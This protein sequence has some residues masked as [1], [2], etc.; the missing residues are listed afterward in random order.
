MSKRILIYMDIWFDK[1]DEEDEGEA[2]VAA[3]V[4]LPHEVEGL[5]NT[6][7]LGYLDR[8][9]RF[10]GIKDAFI[11]NYKTYPEMHNAV[12]EYI[13]KW[14]TYAKRFGYRFSYNKEYYGLKDGKYI[15]IWKG[16]EE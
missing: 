5:T 15:V 6:A 8:V 1:D 4:V 16:E 3:K 12:D 14:K 13:K 10:P 11:C 7:L 9:E 2:F